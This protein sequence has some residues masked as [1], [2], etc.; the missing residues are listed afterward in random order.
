MVSFLRSDDG[1]RLQGIK[2]SAR[3]AR[4]KFTLISTQRCRQRRDDLRERV[5]QLDVQVTRAIPYRG[6]VDLYERTLEV[7]AECDRVTETLVVFFEHFKALIH[8]QAPQNF[9][10]TAASG[11][12]NESVLRIRTSRCAQP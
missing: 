5:V 8:T 10:V 11:I 9:I 4:Q 2:E 3:N 1:A 6:L 12:G 7:C